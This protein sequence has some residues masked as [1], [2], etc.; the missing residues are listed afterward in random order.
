MQVLRAGAHHVEGALADADGAHA[1]VD[2]P[3][4]EPGL[5]H[6]EALA[7]AAEEVVLRDAHV[8]VPHVGVR[9]RLPL[10]LPEQRRQ[11]RLR[12]VALLAE[13]APRAECGAR[14]LRRGV[15]ATDGGWVTC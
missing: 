12:R 1:V 2:A 9:R 6:H 7:A 15:G 14:V 10:G 13:L 11:A 3:A 5:G 8:R 4:G